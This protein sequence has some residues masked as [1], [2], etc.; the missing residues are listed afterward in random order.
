[1]LAMT[2]PALA[3][4][5]GEAM[6]VTPVK[7]TVDLTCM[8]NGVDARE[9]AL[10]SAYTTFSSAQSAALLARASALH[11]AWGNTDA[12]ARRTALRAAWQTY[13]TAHRAAVSAHRT[14]HTSAWSAFRT[15]AK[16]CKG[17]GYEEPG[18]SLESS[19]N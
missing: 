5:T 9:T 12:K 14:A 18:S 13:R 16:A 4:E 11:T 1:M 7:K 10:Q 15:A 6:H 3:A 8:V 19:L 2:A 17:N